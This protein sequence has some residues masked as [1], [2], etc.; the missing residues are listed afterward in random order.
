MLTIDADVTP[1]NVLLAVEDKTLF[2]KMEQS[3]IEKPTPQKVLQD[4]LLYPSR[5][6]NRLTSGTPI[7]CDLSEARTGDTEHRGYIM[8][9]PYRAPEVILGMSWSSAVDI[10]SVGLMVSFNIQCSM[11]H[12]SKRLMRTADM[13]PSRSKAPADRQRC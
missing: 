8:C 7:L 11:L 4:R 3:E 12:V 10:W 2:Q 9:D 5:L 6:I 1:N 13:G